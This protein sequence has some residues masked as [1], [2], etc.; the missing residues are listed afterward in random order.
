MND[1]GVS[2]SLGD[3]TISHK[4]S[5]MGQQNQWRRVLEYRQAQVV[6]S[7]KRHVLR[8]AYR[9]EENGDVVNRVDSLDLL[10][11]LSHTE[12]LG[13]IDFAPPVAMGEVLLDSR[14]RG[15]IQR[16]IFGRL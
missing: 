11:Y 16:G 5:V 14:N 2:L 15:S 8:A 6:K 10:D 7:A 13:Y 4:R 9:D 1:G 12:G 3:E